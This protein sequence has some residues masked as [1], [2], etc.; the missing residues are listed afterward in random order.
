MWDKSLKDI[1]VEMYRAGKFESEISKEICVPK[2]TISEWIVNSN[3]FNLLPKIKNKRISARQSLKYRDA[4]R[5]YREEGLNKEITILDSI[6]AGLYWGEGSKSNG[7]WSMVNSDPEVIQISIKWLMSVGVSNF[8]LKIRA[9]PNPSVNSDDIRAYW[10]KNINYSTDNILVF[11]A[12]THPNSK[13][14]RKYNP[15]GTCEVKTNGGGARL[16]EIICG[17]INKIIGKDINIKGGLVISVNED[18]LIPTPKIRKTANRISTRKFSISP[19]DLR[20]MV[21]SRPTTHVSK[22]LGVSDSAIGKRCKL[23][24]IEKPPRGYWRKM[25]SENK[26]LTDL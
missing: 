22:L 7:I 25:E 19:E 24:G 1:A 11:E 3:Q 2:S 26:K 8:R 6:M 13:G 14:T 18:D 12:K 21:W 10:A 20:D 15:Y 23:L 16:Y 5:V 17:I 9:Y 4:R